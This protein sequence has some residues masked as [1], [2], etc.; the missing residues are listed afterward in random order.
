VAQFIAIYLLIIVGIFVK[1]NFLGS[2]NFVIQILIL[3]SISYFLYE[4]WKERSALDHDEPDELPIAVDKEPSAD[5]TEDLKPSFFDIKV[6]GFKTL[7]E[8]HPG[9]MDFMINQFMLIWD[10][11]YPK[12]GY[13]IFKNEKDVIS[14][15]HKNLQPE[16]TIDF[17]KKPLALLKLI[18]NKDGI[19][20]ENHIDETLHLIPFY[21][22]TSYKPKS[23][24]G[25]V[26]PIESAERLY[27]IFDSDLS[28]NFNMED[29]SIIERIR[30]NTSTMSQE[31]LQQLA[32]QGSFYHSELKFQIARRLNKAGRQDECLDTFCDF[33]V[34]HF[35]AAKLTIA[36][37]KNWYIQADTAIIQKTIGLDDPFKVGF[38][39]PIA[40][41]LNGWVI[42]KNK[43]HLIPDIEQ[44]EYFVPRFSKE[45]K[46][47]YGIRSF[48]SVPITFDGEAIGMVTLEENRPNKYSMDDKLNLINFTEILAIALNR[49]DNIEAI[50]K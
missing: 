46:S 21:Q 30:K 48:L 4:I 10:F 2:F 14:L 25:F 16:I 28:E 13:I 15:I 34:D 31:A 35:Q 45:E 33:V 5:Q 39:F 47:N 29:L 19:L 12:N 20:V 32:M 42:M 23:L 43:P 18:E 1:F 24:L 40:E 9:Y 7:F 3:A 38:E 6:S 50:N 22:N 44:G 27:W 37:R 17:D 11:I 26:L 41:G 36:I 8:H 49:F